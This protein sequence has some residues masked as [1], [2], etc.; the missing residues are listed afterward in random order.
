MRAI[1]PALVFALSL[2][3]A[4]PAA[5]QV[6]VYPGAH[7]QNPA[8]PAA[9][10]TTPPAAPAPPQTGATPSE[11]P[12]PPAKPKPKPK[13]KVQS[14]P[15]AKA[16]PPAAAPAAPPAPPAAAATPPA[17]APPAVRLGTAPENLTV[18]AAPPASPLLPPAAA[19]PPEHPN[20]TP[21]PPPVVAAAAG[22]VIE[23]PGGTRITFAPESADLNPATDA[24]LR[25]IGSEA[26][27]NP[28]AVVNVIAYASGAKED[29]STPRRLSLDRALAARA[30]LMA[31]GVPSTRIYLR[32]LGTASRD[33]PPDRV[34]LVVVTSQAAVAATPP[35]PGPPQPAVP[36]AAPNDPPSEGKP[37]PP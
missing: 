15:A 36:N 33:G 25:Q 27:K 35:P 29:P 7:D 9:S 11:T 21:P 18:P 20:V 28:A 17:E 22:E 32:A 4:L 31:A 2:A 34:D 12:K 3:L 30:V 5:A 19:A 1:V 10:A 6:T 13:P 14:K 16:K 24:A 23:V 8:A 26:A 37:P